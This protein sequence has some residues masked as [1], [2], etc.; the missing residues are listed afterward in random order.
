MNIKGIGRCC[1]ELFRWVNDNPTASWH[2]NVSKRRRWRDG[3]I[4][5]DWQRERER[6]RER[7]RERDTRLRS[8]TPPT[9]RLW[10]SSSSACVLFVWNRHH[11]QRERDRDG[12][13]EKSTKRGRRLLNGSNTNQR[14]RWEG[15]HSRRHQV[16]LNC[17]QPNFWRQ[18][19]RF[20]DFQ[21][22][23]CTV[24]TMRLDYQ[25]IIN[26]ILN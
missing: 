16:Y 10:R 22:Y 23:F 17:R 6:A 13:R 21:Q 26:I 24:F 4:C 3:Q 11:H 1:E 8:T 15:W 5:R 14:L 2:H 12:E 7:G 9:W 25:L 18:K 19:N 20:D